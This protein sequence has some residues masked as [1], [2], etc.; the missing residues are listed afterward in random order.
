MNNKIVEFNKTQKTKTMP[1]LQS[2]D[3][4][5][6]FRKIKEGEK[7]RVQ[8][9]EGIIIAIKGNQSS[10]P[11]ITVRKVSDGVGVE[12]ILPLF[13][14]NIEKIEIVKRAKVRRGKLYYLRNLTT[15]KSRMRYKDLSEFIIKE[16]SVAAEEIPVEEAES[17]VEKAEA[18]K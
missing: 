8:I 9:F 16:E 2:G 14:P 1:E 7:E 17:V 3:V 11:M 12:L 5:K 10:S 15:K 6:V 4:V 18:G 13:S